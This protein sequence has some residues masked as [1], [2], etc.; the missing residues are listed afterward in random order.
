ML[1]RVQELQ[2][3]LHSSLSRN[4]ILEQEVAQLKKS[5]EPGRG[6]D[7]V[8]MAFNL[9]SQARASSFLQSIP[10]VKGNNTDLGSNVSE[11]SNI[12]DVE[13][14]PHMNLRD[15]QIDHFNRSLQAA[16]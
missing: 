6:Y 2:E 1:R 5:D 13:V 9:A 8:P 14:E 12:D 7:D 16:H 4:R 11:I 10:G 3:A 15:N